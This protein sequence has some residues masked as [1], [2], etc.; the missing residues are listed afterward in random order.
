MVETIGKNGLMPM[1]ITATLSAMLSIFK[2]VIKDKILNIDIYM[3][4][5]NYKDLFIIKFYKSLS[6]T[7][8]CEVTGNTYSYCWVGD[9]F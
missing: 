8:Y 3:F 9:R 6:T 4:R 7:R 2:D 1:I 5:P